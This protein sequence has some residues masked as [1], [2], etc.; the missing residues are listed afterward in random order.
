MATDEPITT[1][2]VAARRSLTRSRSGL[3]LAFGSVLRGIRFA[4]IQAAQTVHNGWG[5]LNVWYLILLRPLPGGLLPL[6]HPYCSGLEPK[7]GETIWGRNVVYRTPPRPGSAPDAEIVR[8]VGAYM[9][10]MVRQVAPRPGLPKGA[11]VRMPAAIYWIH[12]PVHYNSG[13]LLFNDFAEAI[14][15]FSDPAF[16]REFR[17]F[18]RSESREPLLVFR[19]RDPDAKAYADFIG[20]LR[21]E[22]PYFANSNGRGRAPLWGNRSPFPTVNIVTGRW[23]RDVRMLR[24]AEGR[25]LSPR[26]PISGAYFGGAYA[27]P[28]TEVSPLERALAKFHEVRIRLRGARG[29]VYFVD[30]R[31]WRKPLRQSRNGP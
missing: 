1:A 19:Q 27:G 20:F 15:H 14:S 7:S 30:Q 26:A 6:D 18:V 12:G 24:T 16:R 8:A 21:A 9:A 31:R 2:A 10:G 29:N 3:V 4:A 5:I 23:I 28:R 11:P 22:L 17:R 25:R 13:W